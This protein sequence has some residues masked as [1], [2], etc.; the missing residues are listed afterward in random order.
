MKNR[1]LLVPAIGLFASAPAMAQESA[2][3]GTVAEER[4]AD[5]AQDRPPPSPPYPDVPPPIAIERAPD[6]D[7]RN[8]YPREPRV[9]NNR[10]ARI[11]QA[12][13]PISSWQNDEEGRVRYRIDID[14]DGN[15]TD[16]SIIE[17]SGSTALDAK[18]CE[19]VVARTEFTPAMEDKD[20]PIAGS[21]TRSYSWRKREPEMPQMSFSIRYLQGADGTAR[22]C[23]ILKLE[24]DVPDTL[25]NEIQGKSGNAD[26][27][28]PIVGGRGVPYRDENGVPIAKQV[29]FSVDVMVEDVAE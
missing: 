27:C 15:A 10:E 1:Y 28:A 6:S 22:Q 19:V 16:C 13:Y 18:T 9:K 4:G 24:G 23:E 25:R 11:T 12:D 8:R 20:T 21:L 26:E 17:T 7:F 3:D 14:A 2:A 29:T 5:P